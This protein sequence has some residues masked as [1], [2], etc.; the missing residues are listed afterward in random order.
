MKLDD[1]KEALA[2]IVSLQK[3][4][5]SELSDNQYAIYKFAC[6]MLRPIV[7]R[8][9]A[10]EVK[11]LKN[12]NYYY[13]PRCAQSNVMGAGT[14]CPGCGQLVSFKELALMGKRSR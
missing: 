10:M 2:Y 3:V 12:K 7:V 13:C 1:T 14:Y 6:N 9:K 8:N 4:L 5:K 11:V